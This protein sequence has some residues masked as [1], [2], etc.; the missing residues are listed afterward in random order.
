MRPSAA[1]SIAFLL[2]GELLCAAALLTLPNVPSPNEDDDEEEEDDN[3]DEKEDA[4]PKEEPP[5][6]ILPSTLP[7]K[8]TPR[9]RQQPRGQITRRR[10]E[11]SP[12]KRTAKGDKKV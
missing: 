9:P 6:F 1:T 7:V 8:E 5:K 4:L 2:L 3:E 11:G 10:G 12:I